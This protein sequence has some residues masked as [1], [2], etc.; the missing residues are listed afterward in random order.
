MR[1]AGLVCGLWL[2]ASAAP[3]AAQTERTVALTFDDLPYAGE[4]ASGPGPGPGPG[5]SSVEVAALNAKLLDGLRAHRAP[6]MGF[7]V[8]KT[9]R[10]LSAGDS[11]AVLDGWTREGFELGN[12]TWSHADSNRL[13]LDEIEAEIVRGEAS[14]RPVMARVGKPLRYLR[15]PMNHTGD[16]AEKRE[17]VEALAARHGYALAAS[18]IDTSDY[19]FEAAYQRALG[20]G[21]GVCAARIADAYVAYSAVEI[22]YYAGLNV[23]VLGRA[24]AE[25]ALLHVNRIN[26]D[27]LD[28]L[29]GLYAARGYR[30]VSLSQAQSDP[31]YGRPATYATRFGPMWGYRWARELGV[32]VNGA[33]EA[34][35][36]AWVVAYGEAAGTPC[37]A[38]TA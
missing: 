5:L 32:R 35:P 17:G 29:L 20:Q 13:S 27:T 15:M 7:V 31:A 9:L 8:E 37:L 34:E 21:D 30:F 12:H 22:D 38:P 26:V 6:A 33:E 19:V 14:I 11:D 18:T 24:P 36:P 2:L 28:R 10:A 25:V 4:V 16:T 1:V 3:V 23:R